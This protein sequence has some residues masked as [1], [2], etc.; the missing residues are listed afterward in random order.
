MQM[1]KQVERRARVKCVPRWAEAT[2]IITT[3]G[4]IF[5]GNVSTD[6]L[7]G[8]RARHAVGKGI[9]LGLGFNRCYVQLLFPADDTI[10]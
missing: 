9:I 3:Q 7:F 8:Y 1:I 5:R 6:E 10:S 4:Y 2:D